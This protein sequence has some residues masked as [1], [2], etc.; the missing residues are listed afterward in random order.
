M[1]AATLAAGFTVVSSIPSQAATPPTVWADHFNDA[2]G[3]G[4]VGPMATASYAYGLKPAD[5]QRVYGV[6][7]ATGAPTVAITVAY[8][9]PNI[10]SDLA[11]YRSQFGLPACTTANGCFKKVNQTGGTA[12]PA[13][14]IGWGQELALDVDMVSAACPLCKILVVEANSSNFSDLMPAV[15]YAAANANYVS[16]SWGTDE[17][18]Q[19]SYYESQFNKPGKV[20]TFSTGDN[21]FGVSYPASS[22]YVVAVGGTSLRLDSSGNRSSETAWS[23]A[24]SG[25]SAYV[26]KPSWQKDTGCARR[27]VADVSAVADPQTGVAVYTSYGS[28]NGNWWVFGGTSA[29]AP[30]IA[31]T[32]AAAG[33]PASGTNPASY[34][35]ANTTGLTDITSGS[36]G[37]CSPAYLCT[38]VTGFDGPTG[39]GVPKG[40]A[41]FAA[42]V[43]TPSTTTSTTAAPTTTS[44]T[45][46]PVTNKAPVISSLTKSCGSTATCTFTATASDPEGKALTYA[47]TANAST[48]KTAKFTFTTTG[49]RTVTVGVGDGVNTTYKSVSV[50]CVAQ[51]TWWGAKKI[52]CS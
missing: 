44:T 35:Y 51:T 49:T 10:E 21:G 40:A 34:P 7:A 22:Q 13:P 2:G 48:T 6:P 25:C 29:S 16:N 14:D 41:S 33:L 38:A 46:P 12:L 19:V 11:A 15:N 50:N 47:W 3:A 26:A 32:Y 4:F 36:N 17:F 8:D 24:G 5:L 30:F 52:V 28:T 45:A 20:M 27:S 37:T 43:T 42:P 9:N 18:S 39:L 1:A 31:G 23:G